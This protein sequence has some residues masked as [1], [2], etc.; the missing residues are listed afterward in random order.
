VVVLKQ[1]CILQRLR[2]GK[3]IRTYTVALGGD[4]VGAKTRQGDH[5]SR[6]GMYAPDSR[7]EHGQCYKAI[8]SSYPSSRS[9]GGREK[10]IAPGGEVFLHGLPAYGWIGRVAPT[11]EPSQS[12]IKRSTRSGCWRRW[13][14]DRDPSLSS[15]FPKDH[16]PS[17]MKI[18][19]SMLPL[20][21]PI[22]CRFCR[23]SSPGIRNLGEMT[24]EARACPHAKLPKKMSTA[25]TKTKRH[26]CPGT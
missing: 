26:R 18:T 24:E 23:G 14:R 25:V 5:I 19:D 1:E 6:E 8:H 7:N 10:G 17:A 20:D 12:A 22:G 16:C 15:E 9:R 13:N 4:P 3:V 2:Q 21:S 11:K